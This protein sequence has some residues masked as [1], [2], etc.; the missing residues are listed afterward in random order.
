MV[1]KTSDLN[2]IPKKIIGIS[3]I[4]ANK[5]IGDEK[6]IPL[7]EMSPILKKNKIISLQYGNVTKEIEK[8]NTIMI[9]AALISICDAVV[10]CRMLRLILLD[11]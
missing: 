5:K 1:N 4:S 10:T 9:L 2:L 7:N 6:S 8:M 11:N 3:W